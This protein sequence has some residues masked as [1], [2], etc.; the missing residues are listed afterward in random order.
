MPLAVPAISAPDGVC[1]ASVPSASAPVKDIATA[2]AMT[3]NFA[4]DRM[5]EA[6]FL[7]E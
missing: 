7:K 2:E 5:S 1:E 6:D 4:A 3:D